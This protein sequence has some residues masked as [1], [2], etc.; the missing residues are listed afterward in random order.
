MLL[1]I[2]V[3]I[4]CMFLFN[5]NPYQHSVYLTSANGVASAVYK[6][7]NNVTSYFNLREINY[8]LQRNNAELE[9]QLL[10]LRAQLRKYREQEYA[11]SVKV[12]PALERYSFFI[13][14]VINNSISHPHNFLTIDKGTTDGIAPGMGVIDQ[15]GV[16]GIVNV[17]GSHASRVISLLNSDLRLSCKIK[18]SQHIGSLVWD[19]KTSRSAVLE[20][21]PRHATFKKGD[22]IVTSGYSTTFPYGVPV[23]TVIGEIKDYDDNF[24]A[25]RIKLFTDFSTLSTVRIIADAMEKELKELE[26]DP[27]NPD[28]PS[29]QQAN[30]TNN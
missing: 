22:T 21:I 7:A 11:D 9:Q 15:N 14:H 17:A 6:G 25:L 5:D 12:S 29:T 8:D 4:S 26:S 1:F 30:A 24:Y 19:G 23:G 16:V 18:T 10:N 13:A 27:D 28:N 2:Y 20:E 3:L